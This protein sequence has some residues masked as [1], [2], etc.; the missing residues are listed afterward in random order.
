MDKEKR[1]KY[2]F[3]GLLITFFILIFLIYANHRQRYVGACD[4]YGYFQESLLFKEG[5]VSLETKYPSV[6]YPSVTPLGFYLINGKNLP[7]YPPGF[8][9]LLAIFG[10]VGLEFYVTPLIGLLTAIMIFLNIKLLTDRWTAFLFTVIWSVF[11]IA[12]YGSTSIMSD[13]V[14]TFF[15]LLAYYLYKTEK[16]T[17][18]AIAMA[19]A[20]A[21]RPSNLLF[22]VLLLP[23]LIKDK[24]LWKY[25]LGGIVPAGL[26]GIYNWILYGAPW[27]TGY[28]SFTAELMKEVFP[29]HLMFYLKEIFWQAGPVLI[30]LALYAIW[31][32][33][34]NWVFYTSWFGIFLLFYC[35]WRSGG[36][37]WWWTRFLLPAFPAFFFLA[38]LG[39]KR[40]ISQIKEKTWAFKRAVIVCLIGSIFLTGGYMV[41]RGRGYNMLWVRDLG[42][43][44]YT[45]SNNVAALVPPDSIVGSVELTG[46]LRYYTKIESFFSVHENS[47][48]LVR[49]V[50]KDKKR[51]FLVVEP[52]NHENAMIIKLFN[53]F[54]CERV[55]S[56]HELGG[57]IIMYELFPR[58]E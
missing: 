57:E 5:R 50:L 54:I 46:S 27:R 43:V 13:L 41:Y 12:V 37:V 6:Q 58:P 18:S 31:K 30:L 33:E 25:C 32:R 47:L 36:D 14:A 26:Y 51:A 35:F 34:K 4:W 29:S 19:Y 1:S 52:W 39:Y 9:L 2:I 53:T 42:K 49:D 40:L 20:L 7:Q 24:K 23:I 8:P 17:L 28:Q 21:V 3:Y 44:Y 10:F 22:A 56:W 15:V 55:T 38:A 11:P 48:I 16:V 45:L